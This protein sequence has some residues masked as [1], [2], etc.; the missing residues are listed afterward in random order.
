MRL[1]L[2]NRL[3]STSGWQSSDKALKKTEIGYGIERG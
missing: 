1:L 3:S 2:T